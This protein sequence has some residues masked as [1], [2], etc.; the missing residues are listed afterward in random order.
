MELKETLA[1]S[2]QVDSRN[3]RQRGAWKFAGLVTAV[4]S[5]LWLCLVWVCSLP[6][7]FE[8]EWTFV[9]FIIKLRAG[10][11]TF[12]DFWMA[13]AEHRLTLSQSVLR[14]FSAM[15]W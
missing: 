10:A 14:Y 9:P 6:V 8:D 4:P 12:K 7:L 1:G 11:L 3:R 2:A 13:Y 15:V 5:L